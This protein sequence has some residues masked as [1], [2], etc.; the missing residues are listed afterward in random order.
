MDGY[1]HAPCLF[2]MVSERENGRRI[3]FMNHGLCLF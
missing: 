3:G 2:D 1:G